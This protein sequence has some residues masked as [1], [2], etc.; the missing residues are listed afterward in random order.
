MGI[1]IVMT[2]SYELY[3]ETFGDWPLVCYYSVGWV[4]FFCI[5]DVLV[6]FFFPDTK[7]VPKGQESNEFKKE[8]S[9]KDTNQPIQPSPSTERSIEINAKPLIKKLYVAYY[10]DIRQNTSLHK[11][12][13]IAKDIVC[14]FNSLW[15]GVYGAYLLWK[16]GI[17][18]DQVSDPDEQFYINIAL[19]YFVADS[20]WSEFWNIYPLENKAHHV[21]CLIGLGVC[22]NRG[23][24]SSEVVLC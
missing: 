11:N 3:S 23:M 4:A 8:S 13:N 16:R 14:L 12:K 2:A 19:A 7:S 10:I 1:T 20:V 9:G 5:A 18:W 6:N 24:F 15:C 22:T 17:V 21:A